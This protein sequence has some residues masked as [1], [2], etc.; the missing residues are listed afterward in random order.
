MV[1]T[2]ILQ[3]GTQVMNFVNLNPRVGLKKETLESTKDLKGVQTRP[4]YFQT[5]KLGT[6]LTKT[7][8]E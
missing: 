5:T 6:S 8:E 4:I 3:L 1:A 2:A 7:G